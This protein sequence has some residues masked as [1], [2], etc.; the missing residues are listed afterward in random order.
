MRISPIVLWGLGLLAS[1][2]TPAWADQ[3]RFN[4]PGNI[5]VTDQFNDR[6]FIITQG[7]ATVFQYGML[8]VIGNGPNQLN[9]PYS[10]VVIGDYTGLTPPPP[11]GFQDLG[12][13]LAD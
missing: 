4:E 8:N 11:F 3:G 13:D 10:A 12:D 5:L 1:A 9:A 2:V 6:V 7:K